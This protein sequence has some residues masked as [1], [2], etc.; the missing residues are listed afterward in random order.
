MPHLAYFPGDP[1]SIQ[2]LYDEQDMNRQIA[3]DAELKEKSEDWRVT[4]YGSYN[5]SIFVGVDL[6]KKSDYTAIVFLEPFLPIDPEEIADK[7]VYHISR[8][9]RL[10]LE[11][12]YPKV[13][14]LLR[15]IHKQ[16]KKSSDFDYVYFAIDEGGVGAAVTDQVVELLPNADIYRIT[17]SG[18]LRPNWT[19]Y[20]DVTLPKTQ[21]AS[22]LMALFEGRRLWV[23]HDKQKQ[24]EELKDELEEYERKI[25]Q[26]GHDQYGA[27]KI[28]LHDDIATA[29]GMAAW[30][31]EDMGG[32]SN[33][34]MW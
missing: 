9:E 5:K 34:I 21:M 12:P 31:A 26:T 28:G 3:R 17:L 13:A 2:T 16:L 7:Y 11:T 22:T 14:R 18:G 32:G 15:K 6:G 10:P 23:G 33:P 1:W 29:I 8:I 27:M 24:F 30:I 4:E 25:T 20:R 19:T